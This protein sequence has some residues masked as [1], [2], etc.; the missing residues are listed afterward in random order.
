VPAQENTDFPELIFRKFHIPGSRSR[1]IMKG[2]RRRFRKGSHGRSGR[3]QDSSCNQPPLPLKKEN[4][5]MPWR[6]AD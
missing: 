1:L 2:A 5:P 4:R 3:E 6:A